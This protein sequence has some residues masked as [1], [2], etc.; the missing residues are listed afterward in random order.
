MK[1]FEFPYGGTKNVILLPTKKILKPILPATPRLKKGDRIAWVM[2]DLP[3]DDKDTWNR[4]RN[5]GHNIFHTLAF[6]VLYRV[7]KNGAIHMI[8]ISCGFWWDFVNPSNLVNP[9]ERPGWRKFNKSF[10]EDEIK[11]LL[12]QIHN[13]QK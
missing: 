12:R 13:G 10:V 7:Y 9:G 4:Y 5:P 6:E 2:S 3:K 1:K 11:P 8:N